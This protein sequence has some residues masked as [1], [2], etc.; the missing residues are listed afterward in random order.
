[1][2]N[3]ISDLHVIDVETA[4]SANL[5]GLPHASVPM[6]PAAV[7]LHQGWTSN[8][9]YIR[10]TVQSGDETTHIYFADD[11]ETAAKFAE[12]FSMD[13]PRP[14][15]E[16]RC[17]LATRKAQC[18]ECAPVPPY[19]PWDI[20]ST[21]PAAARCEGCGDSSLK[22]FPPE[23]APQA[24]DVPGTYICCHCVENGVRDG[25]VEVISAQPTHI[26]HVGH[27]YDVKLPLD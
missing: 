25:S 6:T 16:C 12:L 21:T 7:T 23:E 14:L 27:G 11:D 26:R 5:T 13:P 3:G 24:S 20:E 4:P 18:P 22:A 19:D 2:S 8:N 1:M 17:G 10:L 15:T 9:N